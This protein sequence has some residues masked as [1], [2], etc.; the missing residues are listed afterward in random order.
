VHTCVA[1]QR[2][3]ALQD[4]VT[5]VPPYQC[6]SVFIRGFIGNFLCG[7]VPLCEITSIPC[8]EPALGVPREALFPFCG[9]YQRD[10][11]SCF[12]R[13]EPAAL[14]FKGSCRRAPVPL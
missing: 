11:D 4:E 13:Q 14:Q 7:L 5:L 6:L 2:S 3:F 1:A 9:F 12:R 10:F 8:P